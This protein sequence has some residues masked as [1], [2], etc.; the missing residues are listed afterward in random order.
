MKP[1]RQGRARALILTGPGKGKTTAALGVI[2]RSLSYGKRALLVRFAK[3][4]RSG[5]L[6][7]LERQPGMRVL[8]GRFGMTPSPDHPEYPEHAAAARELFREAEELAP[9]FDLIVLDEICGLTSRGMLDERAVAAFVESLGPAQSVVLTGRGAGSA[10]IAVADTV[11]EIACVKHGYA[12]GIPAQ[13]GIE[14]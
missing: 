3:A 4:R 13:E 5:E 7:I 2:L 6:D 14:L 12:R 9:D 1:D 11:S 8:G 10:L